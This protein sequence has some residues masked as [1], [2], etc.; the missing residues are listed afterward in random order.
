[1]TA[2]NIIPTAP[3]DGVVYATDVPLTS[4]EATLGD[5]LLCPVLIP[6]TYGEAIVAVVKLTING[7]IVANNTYVVLQMDMGDGTWIDINWLVWDGRQGSAT[8]L[9]SNGIAGANSIQQTRQSGQVPTPQTNGS[10][11]L[12]LG[13]RLRFV[14][15]SQFAG[16]SSSVAGVTTNVKATITYKILGLR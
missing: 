2:A 16:G 1:M 14:G 13:G 8:F 7:Y 9:F 4:T 6:T 10:N 3:T 11:Q 15:K 5:A 12:A